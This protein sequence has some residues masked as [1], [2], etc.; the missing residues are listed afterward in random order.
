MNMSAS[1]NRHSA[2]IGPGAASHG[3]RRLLIFQE[4]RPANATEQVYVPVNKLGLP[5]CG[6]GPELPSILE[7]PLRVLRVFTDIFNQP[8]YKGWYVH[9]LVASKGLPF[10]DF[11]RAVLSAG[12]YYDTGEEGKFYAVVLE[13]TSV[14]SPEIHMGTP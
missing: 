12:P 14:S 9:G 6:D 1:S 2:S 11:A 13:Q 10:T 8:K 3:A 4:T 5:I 7:L